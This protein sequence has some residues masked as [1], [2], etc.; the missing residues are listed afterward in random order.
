MALSEKRILAPLNCTSNDYLDLP[1]GLGEHGDKFIYIWLYRSKWSSPTV[2]NIQLATVVVSVTWSQ[3]YQIFEHNHF[4]N[5]KTIDL[6]QTSV[7]DTT[8]MSQ[9][10]VAVH[11]GW[12]QH[13][14][15]PIELS[16][17]W[18]L[19]TNHCQTH[20]ELIILD[21]LLAKHVH[22]IP[23]I[24]PLSLCSHWLNPLAWCLNQQAIIFEYFWYLIKGLNPQF[25]VPENA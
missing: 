7:E 11:L 21:P 17:N 10:L 6:C 13:R 5:A 24:S 16:I 23:F 8:L 22:Q 20:P 9:L 15:F 19:Y 3:Q 1:L 18:V 12:K 14:H 4:N 2:T 25:A